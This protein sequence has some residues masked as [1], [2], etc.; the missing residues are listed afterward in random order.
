[1]ARVKAWVDRTDCVV[2]VQADD[3]HRPSRRICATVFAIK[4]QL[5][6]GDVDV[7]SGVDEDV[8]VIVVL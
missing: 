7:T 6:E 8:E 4:R 3:G 5:P 2:K 1:V